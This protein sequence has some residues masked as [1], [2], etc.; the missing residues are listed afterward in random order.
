MSKA[1]I[2]IVDDEE[3]ILTAL[4]YSLER[5]GYQTLTARNGARALETARRELPDLILLD[6]MLPEVDGLEVCRLLRQDEKTRTIPVILLTVRSGETDKV[7][8]LEIGADD[9]VTK[10]FSQRELL[11]RIRVALRRAS[12]P[13]SDVF[14]LG[15]FQVDWGRHVVSFG[16]EPI[17]LT[18]KEFQLLTALIDAQGRVLT[19]EV[20]LDKVWGYDRAA[21]IETRT[22][23]LHISQLRRKLEPLAGRIL[24]LNKVG[25][26]FVIDE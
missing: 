7:L 13:P 21:Q 15:E 2:L 8:G 17:D 22:V 24:T 6:W 20:L 4:A 9:Y 11:A 25:Y 23:D 14:R 19:R 5:E 1:R 16:N 26:R 18:P 12:A 10:P 3:N